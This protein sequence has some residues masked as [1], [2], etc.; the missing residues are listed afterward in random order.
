[1]TDQRI[2]IVP[3]GSGFCAWSPDLPGCIAT[4]QTEEETREHMA[5][6]VEMHLEGLRKAGRGDPS[7]TG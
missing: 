2:L 3:T 5:A 1:M 7:D 4:G 6:A